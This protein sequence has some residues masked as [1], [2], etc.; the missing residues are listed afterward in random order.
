MFCL[1]FN[2]SFGQDLAMNTT[3]KL[4]KKPKV[5]REQSKTVPAHDQKMYVSDKSHVYVKKDKKV[6]LWISNSADPNSKKEMLV[7]SGQAAE[8]FYLDTEGLN[9]I[10]SPWAV[11]PNTQGGNFS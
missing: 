8:Y 3:T 2:I 1:F 11:D 10:R 6:Y 5:E 4:V 7:T 9:T